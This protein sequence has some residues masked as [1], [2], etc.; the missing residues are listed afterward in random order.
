MNAHTNQHQLFYSI[1]N[2]E[3]IP[4]G[5][6]Y[7]LKFRD[8]KGARVGLYSYNRLQDGGNAFFNWFTF[9]FN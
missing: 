4:C 9:N 7:S 3:F 5:K 6:P 2:K 1:N 8:W